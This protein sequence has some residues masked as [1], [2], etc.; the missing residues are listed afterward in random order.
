MFDL[1]L[2]R[3]PAQVDSA[4]LAH[5]A[6]TEAVSFG[7][8]DEKYGEVLI[9]RCKFRLVCCIESMQVRSGSLYNKIDLCRNFRASMP[10]KSIFLHG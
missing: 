2:R 7:A 3:T 8:P 6:V 5:P 4:L 1:A 10:A 9:L